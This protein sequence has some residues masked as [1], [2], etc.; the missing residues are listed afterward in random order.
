MIFKDCTDGFKGFSG[1][2]TIECDFRQNRA[3]ILRNGELEHYCK[4]EFPY[5]WNISNLVQV[6]D[7]GSNTELFSVD[8]TGSDYDSW[9]NQIKLAFDQHIKPDYYNIDGFKI[10][11]V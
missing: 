10:L 7:I 9:V 4:L 2:V 11:V 1:N 3:A 8:L 5:V 6:I